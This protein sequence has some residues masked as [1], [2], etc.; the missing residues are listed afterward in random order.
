MPL[1]ITEETPRFQ[2]LDNV[3]HSKTTGRIRH[4]APVSTRDL[5]SPKI[6]KKKSNEIKGKISPK[7]N[8]ASNPSFRTSSRRTSNTQRK[9]PNYLKNIDSKIKTYVKK[10]I[11]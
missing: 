7:D 4:G 3:F 9:V 1:Y 8:K 5:K 6:Y 10:D 11:E 2:D